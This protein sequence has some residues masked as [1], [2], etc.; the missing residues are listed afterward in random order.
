MHKIAYIA[1]FLI[2]FAGDLEKLVF[3]G[4]ISVVKRPLSD[5]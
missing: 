1:Q 4:F 3:Y 5:D 2:N